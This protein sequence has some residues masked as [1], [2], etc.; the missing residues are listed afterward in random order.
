MRNA[1]IQSLT[2]IA[3]HV[4]DVQ[5]V[6]D[7]LYRFLHSIHKTY[8]KLN[9]Y[10]LESILNTILKISVKQPRNVNL[11]E[12]IPFLEF[13]MKDG[14][15]FAMDYALQYAIRIIAY[16][17]H[18]N[19]DY[20]RNNSH[21]LDTLIR[22]ASEDNRN[23]IRYM[24]VD[25]IGNYILQCKDDE[26]DILNRILSLLVQLSLEDEDPDVR[27][28][29][30]ESITEYCLATPGESESISVDGQRV[31]IF[32]YYLDQLESTDTQRAENASEAIK[33]LAC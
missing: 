10:L 24:G 3:L 23:F 2:D 33:F 18:F 32:D 1:V 6:L 7:P 21:I 25:A 26:R 27:A 11:K 15:S 8:K 17:L 14:D 9:E 28:K 30:I 5:L 13:T 19:H 22:Y 29:S 12:I 31:I 16:L 20:L 4:N